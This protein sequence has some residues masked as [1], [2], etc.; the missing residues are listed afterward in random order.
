MAPLAEVAG[1]LGGG[2][3][4]ARVL[5]DDLGGCT[6]DLDEGR[7]NSDVGGLAALASGLGQRWPWGRGR[8]CHPPSCAAWQVTWRGRMRPTRLW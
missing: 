4:N 3:F 8:R 2:G 1:S 7:P 6:D 5:D